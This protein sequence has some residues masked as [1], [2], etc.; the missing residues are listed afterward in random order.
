MEWDRFSRWATPIGLGLLVPIVWGVVCLVLIPENQLYLTV[1][2]WSAIFGGVLVALMNIQAVAGTQVVDLLKK[3]AW[4]L[5][6]ILP[7]LALLFGMVS[8]TVSKLKAN[9]AAKTEGEQ[10]AAG[11]LPSF[12]PTGPTE[13]QIIQTFFR[14]GPGRIDADDEDGDGN[15]AETVWQ[16]TPLTQTVEFQFYKNDPYQVVATELNVAGME[17]GRLI[18]QM[19]G[20]DWARSWR[21]WVGQGDHW[22]EIP[23]NG[24]LEI[25]PAWRRLCVTNK[26][27]DRVLKQPQEPWIVALTARPP[28]GTVVIST[29]HDFLPG[30][31]SVLRWGK[32]PDPDKQEW[33]LFLTVTHAS[34]EQER[35]TSLPTQWMRES[36]AR[37]AIVYP[38]GEF[39]QEVSVTQGPPLTSSQFQ[40]QGFGEDAHLIVKSP[41]GTPIR[42]EVVLRIEPKRFEFE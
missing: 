5:A 21:L 26:Y 10:K 17:G 13:D 40:S 27:G 37:L 9:D 31:A 16:H 20:G 18:T 8:S 32:L 19:M 36:P 4:I 39:D 35:S 6:G 38:T 25:S 24:V 2:I 7:A 3:A 30:Q 15:Q 34:T 28:E 41:T 23:F 1:G 42:V 12:G 33:Q 11:N 14:E 22:S 29:F